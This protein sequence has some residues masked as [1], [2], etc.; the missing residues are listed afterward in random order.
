MKALQQTAINYSSDIDLKSIIKN[1]KN[2]QQN[3]ILFWTLILLF[4]HIILYV[5]DAIF[6]KK[7][8]KTN[9]IIIYQ[10]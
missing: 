7:S 9:L 3:H 5:L 8:Y 4:H 2:A 1:T 10:I 6:S